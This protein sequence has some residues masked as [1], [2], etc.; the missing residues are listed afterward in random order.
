MSS[1]FTSQ[2]VRGLQHW[3]FLLRPPEDEYL[4]SLFVAELTELSYGESIRQ[5]DENGRIRRHACFC[6]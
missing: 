4:V 6:P 1:N 5:T 3:K 2:G